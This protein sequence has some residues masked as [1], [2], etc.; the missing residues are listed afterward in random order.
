VTPPA[1]LL[2][3]DPGKSG[4]IAVFAGGTLVGFEPATPEALGQLTFSYPAVLLEKVGGVPG[5]SAHNS[6]KFGRSVG[7]LVGVCL[8]S[9]I[10]P[11]E[12]P[13]QVWKA[14]LGLRRAEGMTQS[15]NKAQSLALARSL[16]P[17]HVKSFARAK[18]D[19]NA[20]AALIGH[21]WLEENLK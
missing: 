14:K 3:I 17:E 8:A 5:Q 9:G 11:I 20:E 13:P 6:F 10:V 21:Y 15:Q 12:I 18:D 19:G 4:A 7:E 2:A 1:I 16:W